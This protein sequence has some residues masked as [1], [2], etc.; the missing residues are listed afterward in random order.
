VT[1]GN[2]AAQAIDEGKPG[3]NAYFS[4]GTMGDV[5]EEVPGASLV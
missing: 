2:I 3:L 4:R 1:Q 5:V